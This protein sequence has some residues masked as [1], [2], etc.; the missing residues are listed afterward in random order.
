MSTVDAVV[1]GS[2]PNGLTGAV[3]LAQAGLSVLVVEAADTIG[4]GTRTVELTVPGVRHDVCSAVHPLGVASPVLSALPLHEHGLTW[5][6][7]DVDL[8]HPLDDGSAGVMVQSLEH[9]AA[10]LGVDGRRWR[11]LFAPLV[12]SFASVADDTLGPLVRIPRHPVTLARF[13]L[14]AGLPATTLARRLATD[15][16]R[17]LFAGSAAHLLQPLTRPLSAS[18]GVMLTT[19]GH[20][21]GWPVAVG[22][23]ASITDALASL[24][25]SLGGQ[26]HTGV[27]VRSMDDIPAAPI[28][29]FDTSPTGAASILGDALPTRTRSAYQRWRYGPGAF[30]VDLAVEGGI[31]WTAQACRRAGTVHLGGTLEEVVATEADIHAGRM[32]QRPFV[33][34]AQQYLADPS[35]SAGNIH[36]VWAYAHVPAGFDGDATDAIINQIERF[37]PGTRERIVALHATSTS[38]LEAYNANYVGGDIATGANSI[39]QLIA[40]PRLAGDPYA[41]GVPGRYLCSAATPPGGGV[42]GMCGHNAALRALHH[43]RSSTS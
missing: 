38:G 36:P 18:V 41:T 39:R 3:T 34:V 24:L 23:S 10:G 22:G 21:N 7:P 12:D 42:H 40:R 31:E 17:A 8:A 35:R 15:Q 26:I 20:R 25:T 9:T 37:A 19:A 30:K 28:V 43:L 32:P 14:R 16:A 33:L 29:L 2:G 4:G 11:K 1:V 5:A 6:W 13:G 27:T